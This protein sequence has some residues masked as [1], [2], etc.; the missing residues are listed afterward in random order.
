M[1]ALSHGEPL[2]YYWFLSCFYYAGNFVAAYFFYF[3]GNFVAAIFYFAGNLV[4]AYFL[5]CRYIF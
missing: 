2:F 5:L 4:A 3:A 1:I